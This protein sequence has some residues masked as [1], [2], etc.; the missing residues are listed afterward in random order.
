M[1][2]F[3]TF[4]QKVLKAYYDISIM[5]HLLWRH[6]TELLIFYFVMQGIHHQKKSKNGMISNFSGSFPTII[7]AD[8]LYFLLKY[9]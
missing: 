8:P 7:I 3:K 5:T 2:S 1:R 4:K 6:K 9:Y